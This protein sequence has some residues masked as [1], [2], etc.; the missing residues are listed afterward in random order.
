MRWVCV[1]HGGYHA[2]W[3]IVAFLHDFLD[4]KLSRNRYMAD[5]GIGGW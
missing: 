4:A 2:S 3:G 1:S 5:Y